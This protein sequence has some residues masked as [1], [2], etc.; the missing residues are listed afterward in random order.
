MNNTYI[1]ITHTYEKKRA[2]IIIY[3]D[4]QKHIHDSVFCYEKI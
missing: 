4:L 2:T 3:N 1:H